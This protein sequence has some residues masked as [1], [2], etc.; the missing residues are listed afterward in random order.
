MTTTI[1]PLAAEGAGRMDKAAGIVLAGG[2][3]ARMGTSKALLRYNDRP[4][5]EHMQDLLRQ[6]GLG[7]VYISGD[8]PGYD[9]IHDAVRHD[10]PAR[11]MAELLARFEGRHERIVFVPVDMPLLRPEA[12]RGLLEQEGSVYYGDYP[13]PACLSTGRGGSPKSV[14]ELLADRKA[15]AVPLPVPPE[16]MV[17]VNTEQ[18]WKGIAS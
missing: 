7:A 6:A 12:L 1:T 14:R 18:E 9:G 15:R 10:G 4:L 5:I 3:S 13:L 8:V 11:A 2:R 16:T 17:N